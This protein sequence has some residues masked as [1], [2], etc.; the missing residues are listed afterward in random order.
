MAL[1]SI[2]KDKS[3]TWYIINILVPFFTIISGGYISNSFLNSDISKIS[4]LSPS[5]AVQ[6]IIFKY[7]YG[8]SQNI[9][10]FYVEL[11][12]LCVV[13]FYITIICGRR[14]A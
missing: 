10:S 14:K 8:Y 5:Y 3:T 2:I 12:V 4:I 7:A 11:L 1:K 13:L 9:N 6:N